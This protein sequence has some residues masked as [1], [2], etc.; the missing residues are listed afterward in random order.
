MTGFGEPQALVSGCMTPSLNSWVIQCSSSSVGDGDATPLGTAGGLLN[1]SDLIE[2]IARLQAVAEA[3][4]V[5]Q[6]SI[7]PPPGLAVQDPTKMSPQFRTEAPTMPRFP[8]TDFSHLAHL[9]PPSAH[10]VARPGKVDEEQVSSRGTVGHPFTCAGPCRYV[11][12]KGGC[13]EGADCPNCHE[14]FWTKARSEADPM[15]NSSN[16][17]GEAPFSEGSHGHPE[18]CA[19]ACKY[20]RRKGGCRDGANCPNCHL[21]HWRRDGSKKSSAA[22]LSEAPGLH[23]PGLL[24]PMTKKEEKGTEPIPE[25]S[26][27]LPFKLMS[28]ET[29]TDGTRPLPG[30]LEER[31]CRSMPCRLI[32]SGYPGKGGLDLDQCTVWDGARRTAS[33]DALTIHL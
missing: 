8:S 31:I 32:T 2:K 22:G 5:L 24:P 23:V 1:T 9:P 19:E 16:A 26:L 30:S 25:S 7:Q 17:I 6:P 28:E 4:N 29:M 18:Q 33:L 20:V 27:P 21:C 12:R 14:C 15:N 11:K 10:P 3:I 13:R